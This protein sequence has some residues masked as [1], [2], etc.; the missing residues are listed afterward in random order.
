MARIGKVLEFSNKYIVF[1]IESLL[2]VNIW[3]LVYNN[4]LEYL[5]L[6]FPAQAPP[7]FIRAGAVPEP[8]EISFYLILTF[9]VVLI[10][11]VLHTYF[12]KRNIE[13]SKKFGDK[14]YFLIK[15]TVLVGLLILFFSNIGSYPMARDPY[16]YQLRSQS[17]YT[18]Y[19][20]AYLL[21][22]AV[23]ITELT[24]LSGLLKI[25]KKFIYFL[26]VLIIGI[27][28]IFTFEPRFPIV[29]HDYSYFL[30]PIWEIAH[31]KTIYTDT[32]S[33]Y[34][35]L[36]I[37]L[38]AFLYK[39]HLL[40]FT[41]LPVLN[42]ILYITQYFL[43]FVL[44][45]KVSKSFGLSLI[46]LFSLLTVNYYSLYHIPGALPQIGPLRWLPLI[47]SLVFFYVFK[48]ID[49]KKIYFLDFFRQFFHHRYRSGSYFSLWIH[50]VF[51]YNN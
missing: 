48:K 39:I 25:S 26:A 14:K 28:A 5:N 37:V 46:A 22:V 3:V 30:G 38:L 31:G 6:R 45:Y 43:A 17:V 44:I 16:P 13:I 15:L 27:I 29:G 40:S 18:L 35:F 21:V 2:A 4:L 12:I 11:Y 32:S 51:N 10:I 47:L 20:L 49:S 42:W 8:F 33:Q 19:L 23:I 24:L 50:F 34:G 1:A 36:S 9:I 7:E 41:Y